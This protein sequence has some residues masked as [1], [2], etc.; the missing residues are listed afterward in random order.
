MATWN[1]RGLRGFNPGGT[2]KS[3]TNE[4]YR[5]EGAGTDTEDPDP[6]HSGD[7]WTRTAATLHWP[8]LSR[9]VP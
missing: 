2:C 5:A 6:D 7:G 8:I 1:S 3:G 4:Q 9:E